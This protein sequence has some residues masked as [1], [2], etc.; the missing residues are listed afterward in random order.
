MVGGWDS[1]EE[2]EGSSELD[3]T[4]SQLVPMKITMN[5]GTGLRRKRTQSRSK[6]CS[7]QGDILLSFYFFI[8]HFNP[9]LSPFFRNFVQWFHQSH[10]HQRERASFRNVV[11]L[12]FLLSFLMSCV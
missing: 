12:S 9:F 3:E 5:I 2:E 10:F 1:D 7:F 4:P 11:P 6:N 8:F